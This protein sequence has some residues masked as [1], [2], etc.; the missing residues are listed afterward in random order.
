MYKKGEKMDEEKRQRLNEIRCKGVITRYQWNEYQKLGISNEELDK[1]ERQAEAWDTLPREEFDGWGEVRVD[2]LSNGQP[3]MVIVYDDG[4]QVPFASRSVK[5]RFILENLA[6]EIPEEGD[7]GLVC[8]VE[9][10]IWEL[11]IDEIGIDED[12]LDMLDQMGAPEDFKE[13]LRLKHMVKLSRERISEVFSA[14]NDAGSGITG[15]TE[16]A[17]KWRINKA[18]RWVLK[19][20]GTTHQNSIVRRN[21][22]SSN[23]RKRKMKKFKS[24]IRRIAKN[25][26]RNN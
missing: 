19:K 15:I 17:V 23:E 1:L 6:L 25:A 16:D 10:D 9:N 11:A 5:Q 24:T 20:L 22:Y 14:N 13:I 4:I 8:T 21:K 3:F 18:E 12:V 2:G 26:N 7:D